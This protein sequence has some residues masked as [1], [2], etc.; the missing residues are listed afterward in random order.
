MPD[1]VLEEYIVQ[2]LEAST[3]SQI[4]FSWHGGEP[5]LAGID[6][7]RRV[8]QLQQ[9]HR[10]AGQEILNGLITNGTLLNDDWCRF[11]ADNGFFV[12]LS[13]DGPQKLHDLYRVDKGGAGTFEKVMRGYQLLRQH[14]ISPDILCVVHDQN[15]QFP[16]EVYCFFK[17]I[18]ASYISFLPLVSLLSFPEVSSFSVPAEAFGR[19]LCT[20]F[21]EWKNQ[22]IGKVKIQIFEEALRSAFKMGHS[23]CIFRPSC[24]DVP[25]VEHNGECYSC[26]HYVDPEHN[27]GNIVEVPLA[28][29]LASP[30]QR[31]FGEAKLNSLPEYCRRCEVREM[32]NGGCPKN[33]FMKTPDGEDG[34]N[35][36]CAGYKRFF[37][38]CQPFVAEVAAE[39]QRQSR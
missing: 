17:Q 15:V 10:S 25:V 5:T 36:L 31:A 3:E 29:L 7:F 11:L 4:R 32:C 9:K 30:A 23:L 16:Q 14:G 6:F 22:D 39:W 12:G 2:H 38:H 24:G 27:L 20:I 37:N 26:D 13:L 35:Y 8:V 33:R 19:F 1:L 28:E 18:E 34:L 21:D